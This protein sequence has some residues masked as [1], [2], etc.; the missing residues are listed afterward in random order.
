MANVIIHSDERKAEVNRTLRDY[1]INPDRATKEQKDM[2]DCI[3]HKT[4]EA[5]RKLRR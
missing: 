1:G 4:S 5:Y 3:A 2:A